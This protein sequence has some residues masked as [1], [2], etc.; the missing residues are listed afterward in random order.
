MREDLDRVTPKVRVVKRSAKRTKI[1]L[2]TDGS[3]RKEEEIDQRKS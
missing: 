3:R 1:H 2:R